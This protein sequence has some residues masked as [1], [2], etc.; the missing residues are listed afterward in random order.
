MC[1]FLK[2]VNNINYCN[3]LSLSL[4]LG[5]DNKVSDVDGHPYTTLLYSNGP[6][7]RQPRNILVD[8][9]KDFVQVRKTYFLIHER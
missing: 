2:I 9:G 4:S 3:Q 1:L 7:Y 5:S 6:G 8:T